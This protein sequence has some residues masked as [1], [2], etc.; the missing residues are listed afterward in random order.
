MCKAVPV[1]LV[2]CKRGSGDSGLHLLVITMVR[3]AVAFTAE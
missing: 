2:L 3:G 1:I